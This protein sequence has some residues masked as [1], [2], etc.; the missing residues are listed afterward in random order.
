MNIAIYDLDKTLTARATYTPFLIFAARK[1]A[2]LRLIFLPVWIAAMICYKLGLVGRGNLKAFGLRIMCGPMSADILDR[3]AK[4]FAA[5][6]I[7]KT[8]FLPGALRLLDEDQAAGATIVMATAAFEF[9]ARYFAEMLDI[10]IV[11][12]SLWD[13]QSIVGGNCY[14]P[15]KKERVDAWL[16]A[17]GFDPASLHIRFVS[18]SFADTPLL[19]AADDA[20]FN[21]YDEAAS[22]RARARGWS[23]HDLRK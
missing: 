13:G 10:N 16:H 23:V 4:G 14:G 12:G 9:Y 7:A 19:D 22:K 20:I 11:I 1:A 6:H 18:D 2:P 15:R 8:G 5:H 3:V 21:T 17:S